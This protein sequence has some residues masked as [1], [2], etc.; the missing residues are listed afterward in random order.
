[1][2]TEHEK[3]LKELAYHYWLEDGQ[4][5]GEE[6]VNTWWGPIQIKTI[7]WLKAKI[8]AD[9]D[10]EIIRDIEIYNNC[11]QRNFK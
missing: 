9:L 5:N 7:H 3:Y 8:V 4:P 1:M 10:R 6:Y 2:E 11:M